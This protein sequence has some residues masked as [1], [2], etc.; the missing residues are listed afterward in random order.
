MSYSDTIKNISGSTTYTIVL[1]GIRIDASASSAEDAITNLKTAI[2]N[3][4]RINSFSYSLTASSTKLIFEN[5]ENTNF[6]L[7]AELQNS[8]TSSSSIS[9]STSQTYISVDCNPGFVSN[10]TPIFDTGNNWDKI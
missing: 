1:N 10:L 3:S 7:T 2:E 5:I 4:N 6:N 9:N 8:A